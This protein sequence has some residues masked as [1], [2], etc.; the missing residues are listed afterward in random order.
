M[1]GTEWGGAVLMLIIRCDNNE[2]FGLVIRHSLQTNT[3]RKIN[4]FFLSSPCKVSL[5]VN[6]MYFRFSESKSRSSE[7]QYSN[8]ANL[9]SIDT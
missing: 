3:S 8:H 1:E 5:V 4:V 9:N 2:L 6:G 7:L